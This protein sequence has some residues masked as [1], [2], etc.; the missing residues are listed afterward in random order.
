[1][2]S[3]EKKVETV[4]FEGGPY[5]GLMIGINTD[6]AF[7]TMNDPAEPMMEFLYVRQGDKM[8]CRNA[9]KIKPKGYLV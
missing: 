3:L 7:M 4:L 1:M 5:N 2:D 8:V 6:C 9:K